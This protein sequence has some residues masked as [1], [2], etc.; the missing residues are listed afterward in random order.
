MF[1]VTFSILSVLE[2]MTLCVR[3]CGKSGMHNLKSF[4]DIL[5]PCGT[6]ASICLIPMNYFKHFNRKAA[7]LIFQLGTSTFPKNYLLNK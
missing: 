3:C 6:P 2:Y 5:E 1:S 7:H 4:F